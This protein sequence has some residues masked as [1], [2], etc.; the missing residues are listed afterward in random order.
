MDIS[1]NYVPALDN[2]KSYQLSGIEP[3][4]MTDVYY[5]VVGKHRLL[6]IQNLIK[7][8]LGLPTRSEL[9]ISDGYSDGYI[10][11]QLYDDEDEPLVD[12]DTAKKHASETQTTSSSTTEISEDVSEQAS[13]E[14][15]DGNGYQEDG[16][17]YQVEAQNVATN[18]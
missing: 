13:E 16:D 11:K 3:D 12:D 7:S 5:Q 9:P 17:G 4:W 6:N 15:Y 14:A 18:E 10:E 8:E 2:I 1:K